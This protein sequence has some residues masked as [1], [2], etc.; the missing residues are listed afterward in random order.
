MQDHYLWILTTALAFIQVAYGNYM[1]IFGYSNYSIIPHIVIALLML[2]IS[3][4]AMPSVK[5]QGRRIAIGNVVLIV[6]NIILGW[7][8]YTFY[9]PYIVFLHF[10]LGLG[11]LSN[12]I[13]LIAIIR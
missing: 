4:I 6:L 10:I 7:F 9:N 1:T 13:I 3:L 5:G 2:I 11:I 12:F 8:I